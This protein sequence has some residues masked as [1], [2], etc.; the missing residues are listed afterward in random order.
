MTPREEWGDGD[1]AD[2]HL[3]ELGAGPRLAITNSFSSVS[4][5]P[6]LLFLL[7]K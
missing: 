3:E 6:S 4:F 7:A 2:R 1:E 5:V